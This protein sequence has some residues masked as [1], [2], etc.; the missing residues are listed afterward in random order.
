MQ[1]QAPYTVDP[2]LAA[3][4]SPVLRSLVQTMIAWRPDA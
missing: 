1:E 4:L 3:R 2:A